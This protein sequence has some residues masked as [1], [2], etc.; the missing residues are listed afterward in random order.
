MRLRDLVFSDLFIGPTDDW[1]WYK[2]TSGSKESQAIPAACVAEVGELR[3]HLQGLGVAR[4]DQRT[5]WPVSDGERFR[6][7]RKTVADDVT[8]FIV[9]RFNLTNLNLKA[10]GLQ[11]AVNKVLLSDH[12]LLQS[13]LVAFVGRTGSGK[14]TLSWSFLLDRLREFGGAAWTV[15][16]PIEVPLQGRHGKG[17][18][19]QIEVD[20]DEMIGDEIRELYRA[21]PDMLMIG[22]V[23]DA[24]TAREAIRAAGSGYL[25][26]VTFHGNDLPSAI[27]Q[28]VRL[29]TPTDGKEE[30]TAAA[31]AGV[32]RVAMYLELHTLPIENDVKARSLVGSEST[33]TPR[34]ALAAQP[35]FFLEKD[36]S[37]R[38]AVRAGDY[39]TLQNEIDRQRRALMNNNLS[40]QV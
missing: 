14:S 26:I 16:N 5:T 11:S 22:E 25:V 6:V 39:H 17:W 12:P 3:R 4:K 21:V 9:R 1:C 15:E 37:P 27:G 38:N 8:I 10:V 31:V 18:C 28:F 20:E 32:L 2:E 36:G 24:R 40:F 35:L 7:K 13:G 34:Q 29:A 23:R 19:Y 30:A 33:G